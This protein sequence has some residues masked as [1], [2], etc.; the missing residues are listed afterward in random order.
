MPGFLKL[1]LCRRWYVCL[2]VYVCVCLPPRLLITS[3]VIWT[4]Y[5]WLNKFYRFYMATAVVIGSGHGL[6]IEERCV[7]Q[8]NKGKWHCINRYIIG[9]RIGGQWG[10]MPLRKK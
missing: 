10:Q 4:P 8:P 7:N 5:G 2:S 3:G 9:A 6:R 1:L